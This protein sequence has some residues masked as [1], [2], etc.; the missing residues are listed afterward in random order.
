MCGEGRSLAEVAS[1]RDKKEAGMVWGA[2][3]KGQMRVEGEGSADSGVD[4]ESQ[5]AWR[6]QPQAAPGLSFTWK[7][8]ELGW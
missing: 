2:S 5:S 1:G 7:L 4:S 6:G 3:Y 8:S